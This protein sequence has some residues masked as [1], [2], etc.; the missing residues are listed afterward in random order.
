[1]Y[2]H[3]LGSWFWSSRLSLRSPVMGAFE[4]Y[5]VRDESPTG[6]DPIFWWRTESNWTSFPVMLKILCYCALDNVW[7]VPLNC[8]WPLYISICHRKRGGAVLLLWDPLYGGLV[9]IIICR[10][11]NKIETVNWAVRIICLQLASL[12]HDEDRGESD[13]LHASQNCVDTI[14]DL[15]LLGYA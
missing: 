2:V 3:G 1:M 14:E 8:L 7:Y 5:V 4:A 12:P 11:A 6:N 9:S 15:P 13:G 10:W